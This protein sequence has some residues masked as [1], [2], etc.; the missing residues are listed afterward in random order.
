M[1]FGSGDES[2]MLGG[3]NGVNLSQDLPSGDTGHSLQSAIISCTPRI[4]RVPGIYSTKIPVTAF[5]GGSSLS[6]GLPALPGRGASAAVTPQV[7]WVEQSSDQSSSASGR[8]ESAPGE[9]AAAERAQ[10]QSW[11]GRIAALGDGG[12][13]RGSRAQVGHVG[14]DGTGKP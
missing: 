7:H 10:A 4:P 6:W 8:A 2:V 9:G 14:E 3:C 12:A 13:G 1:D 5:P 11:G